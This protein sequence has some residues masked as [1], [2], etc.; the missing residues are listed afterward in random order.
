VLQ[1]WRDDAYIARKSDALAS[2]LRRAGFGDV[3]LS[4]PSRTQPGE[5]RRMDL[6]ARRTRDGVL[7]GLHRL[8]NTEV[9]DFNTCH[10]LHPA[11]VALIAPARR[12]LTR[13]QALHR[14]G[15]LIANLLDTG[16]DLLLRTDATLTL[17]DRLAVNE[18]ARVQNL[19]RVSWAQAN[20]EVEPI[21]ILRPPVIALSGVAVSPP[22]G[23]F[24]QASAAGEAAIVG[25]VLDALPDKLPARARIA[26]LYA[27]C[28]TITFALARRGRVTAWEGDGA[29]IAALRHAANQA[30]L[31][32]RV[33]VV[34]RDLARQ[35][36]M[37]KELAGVAAVVLD[38]PQG[39]AAAQMVQIAVA[40][41]PLVIHVSCNPATLARDA[42]TLH[43]AGYQL[44]SARPIDQFLWSERLESVC[45]FRR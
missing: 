45:S 29:S 41:P 7:L 12:L 8:R 39:G 13:M 2:A 21:C 15:S 31:A 4:A 16:V 33:E 36:V 11:L 35:P 43:H 42:R 20:G 30:G 3:A 27:G 1:H 38:P 40:R 37:A 24:L 14:D 34:Q 17:T 18:F 28:G 26:E 5:R 32:G 44:V 19:P 23:A 6:A 25:A 22:P 10:V 9:V